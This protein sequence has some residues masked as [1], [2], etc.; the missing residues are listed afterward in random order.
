MIIWINGAFG[1]GKTTCAYELN[2]RLPNSYVYDPENIG[3][4]IRK[5]TPK[6]VHKPDFQNLEQWRLFNYEMLKSL[7]A[8]YDGTVIAPMTLIH[9]Q[10]YD[11]I[12]GRL[13][14]DG[15]DVKHFILYAEKET[16][17]KRL[18]KRLERSN[19]WARARI[20]RCIDAFNRDITDEKIITDNKS[21]D[22]VVEEIAQRSGLTLMPDNRNR[23]CKYIDRTL[24]TIR[25][26]RL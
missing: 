26:I 12:I 8:V 22:S 10:Y 17:E 3:F 4:F 1:S 11:E 16:I 23:L 14:T 6:E 24:I 19:S 13:I 15:I 25:H 20:E 21:V 2:K 7:S 9:R 18:N 5:N